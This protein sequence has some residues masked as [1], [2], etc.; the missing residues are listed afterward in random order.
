MF[1]LKKREE[2]EITMKLTSQI[3]KQKAKELGITELFVPE[4]NAFE[5]ALVADINVYPVG[6][7]KN[8][9]LHLTGKTKMSKCRF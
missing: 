2:R 1:F 6:N 4:K 3:I 8:L 9:Y 7:I 5:A